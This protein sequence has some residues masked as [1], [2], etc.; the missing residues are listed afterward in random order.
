MG[1]TWMHWHMPHI[2]REISLYGLE[3]DWVVTQNPGSR[4]DY[5]TLCTNKGQL[6]LSHEDEVGGDGSLYLWKETA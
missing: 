1:G 2:Y 4:L 5:S 3:N 6:K